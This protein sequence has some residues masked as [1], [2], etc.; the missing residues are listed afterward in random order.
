MLEKYDLEV[1]VKQ[2]IRYFEDENET[3]IFNY[4]IEKVLRMSSVAVTGVLR[5]KFEYGEGADS[6]T[7]LVIIKI[8]SLSSYYSNNPLE[9]VIYIR[10]ALIYQKVL[11]AMYMLGECEPFSAQL[12]VASQGSTLVLEDLSADGYKPNNQRML[13][14]GQIKKT[15]QVLAK[16]HALSYMYLRNGIKNDPSMSLTKLFQPESKNEV[17][18]Q[19]NT[20][21]SFFNS[22][23]R[24]L[25]A[26]LIRKLRIMKD[27]VHI[28][29]SKEY[30]PTE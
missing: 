3:R 26:T 17:I 1:A 22:L 19:E 11:P 28:S 30:K 12:Y 15:L 8:P 24:L 29:I 10:E 14:L 5:V 9:N 27:E 23:K 13:N 20:Y 25:S 16:F 7:K 6:K 2:F 21:I 18:I 4:F